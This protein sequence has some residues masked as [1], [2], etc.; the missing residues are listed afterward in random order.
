MPA[1][2]ETIPDADWAEQVAKR[3]AQQI[4][5]GKRLCLATGHTPTP[6]YRHI[7]ETVSLDGLSLFLLDEFGGLPLGDP[8]RCQSMLSRDLLDG[9]AGSPVVHVPDVDAAVSDEAAA[10]YGDM[11]RDGGID[12]AIVGLGGNGHIGMNEPGTTIDQPTRVVDL[13]V[14]TSEGAASYGAT[15][16]PTWGITVGMAELMAAG[17][18]WVLVTGGHKTDILNRALH[19]PV[20]PEAPVSFL[21]EHPNCTFLADESAGIIGAA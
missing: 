2:V 12:L 17:E 4:A 16:S 11:I 3:L 15:V 9:C 13:S 6:V 19:G 8:G 20:D 14:A 18:V 10:R 1:T 5:P 7:A 21:T